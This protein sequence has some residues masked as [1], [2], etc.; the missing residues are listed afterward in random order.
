[1]RLKPP[2]W[3]TA[4]YVAA[5][6]V[7]YFP[8]TYPPR[9]SLDLFDAWPEYFVKMSVV[10]M[11]LFAAAFIAARMA[12]AWRRQR[13]RPSA[14]WLV[15]PLVLLVLHLNWSC[16]LVFRARWAHARSEF[17][18]LAKT[19]PST[20]KPGWYGTFRVTHVTSYPGGTLK[21]ALGLP[22]SWSGPFELWR[23]WDN[24][25]AQGSNSLDGWFVVA[26]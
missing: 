11:A 5:A 7:V 8:F 19:P 10:V 25:E 3:L 22:D 17:I 23:D 9:D 1:M 18:A 15:F 24:S 6:G 12:I 21:L 14:Q 16:G 26:R 20:W 2:R 4:A 13:G